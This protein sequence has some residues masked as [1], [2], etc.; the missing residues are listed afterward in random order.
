[1]DLNKYQTIIEQTAVFPKSVDQFDLAYGYLGLGDEW[2]EWTNVVSYYRPEKDIIDVVKEHGDWLWY[3]TAL[4][5]FNNI[6]I[7]DAFTKIMDVDPTNEERFIN[8]I[9]RRMLQFNG[10]IKKFYRD[11]KPVDLKELTYII[12]LMYTYGEHVAK[13]IGY[14]I[15]EV[16][17][18]NYD[19]LIKRRET[20]T[21]HGDGDH[22]ESELTSGTV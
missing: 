17:Q 2:I 19:K 13:R 8:Y 16:L 3:S 6:P 4:C 21:I 15:P 18:I 14:T 7:K 9:N 1:M 11:N 20:N 10:N 5:I 22:R 12:Q